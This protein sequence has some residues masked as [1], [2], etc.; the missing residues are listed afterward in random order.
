MRGG[1]TA[2]SAIAKLKWRMPTPSFDS[3]NTNIRIVGE[4]FTI[5]EITLPVLRNERE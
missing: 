5:K 3:L 1:I 2:I 4:T